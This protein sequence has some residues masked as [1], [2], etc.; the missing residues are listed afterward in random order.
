M[1]GSWTKGSDQFFPCESWSVNY[2]WHW[3]IGNWSCAGILYFRLNTEKNV[4]YGNFINIIKVSS[5]ISKRPG[6]IKIFRPGRRIYMYTL[7][8]FMDAMLSKEK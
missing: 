7:P 8:P 4:L 2:E 6:D 1:S 5:E 3:E